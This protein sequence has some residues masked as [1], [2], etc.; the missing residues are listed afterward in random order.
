MKVF[1]F[2]MLLS[3]ACH[4]ENDSES[5][6]TSSADVSDSVGSNQPL[7]LTMDVG[8]DGVALQAGGK[9]LLFKGRKE[10]RFVGEHV[11]HGGWD[12]EETVASK[13]KEMLRF[14]YAA[15]GMLEGLYQDYR[16]GRNMP[17]NISLQELKRYATDINRG[18][19]RFLAVSRDRWETDED[20]ASRLRRAFNNLEELLAEDRLAL[21]GISYD[22]LFRIIGEGDVVA[23]YADSTPKCMRPVF[24]YFTK[25][26]G[27]VV[28]F[29]QQIIGHVIEESGFKRKTVAE[30]TEEGVETVFGK[31]YRQ[32]FE[33]K[34]VSVGNGNR[35]ESYVK[36]VVTTFARRYRD[37]GS[38]KEKFVEHV[39]IRQVETRNEEEAGVT[40][41][42]FINKDFKE[43]HEGYRAERIKEQ[44]IAM[45]GQVMGVE[46]NKRQRLRKDI[47]A[48]L[49]WSKNIAKVLDLFTHRNEIRDVEREDLQRLAKILA[50]SLVGVTAGNL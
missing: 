1:M 24:N 19:K 26:E 4:V 6:T 2:L 39:A 10:H 5:Q 32:S 49:Y 18:I 47:L 20:L 46:Q 48:D 42:G 28:N 9:E 27:N 23:D 12:I 7:T 38:V 41:R 34:V 45:L 14:A 15:L 29:H 33:K 37:D 21:Y 11:V 8:D 36:R 40:I 43:F 30:V 3:S 31:F 16:H 22:E 25:K 44:T 13:V 35:E 50:S 17:D